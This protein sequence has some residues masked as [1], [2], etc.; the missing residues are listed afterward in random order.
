MAIK[1]HTYDQF[2]KMRDAGRL[3]A[4]VLDYITPYVTEGTSTDE[5]NNLCH[6]YILKH[7]AIPSPL[8]QGFPKS[9]C[10]SVNHVI[11]H[12][13]PNDEKLVEGDILNIDVCLKLNGWH[14]DTSRMFAIGKIARKAQR[15]IEVTKKALE[16]GIKCVKPGAKFGD[17]GRAIQAYVSSCNFSIV[18]D[19][20]GHGIGELLHDEPQVLHY[21]TFNPGAE[22]KEG[23]FFTIEPMIN[24]GGEAAIISNHDGWTVTT[25]DKSLS[26]QWEHTLGVTKDGV[27]IFTL[28]SSS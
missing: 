4:S 21:D 5:L 12:G 1:I 14:G 28:S 26:A 15:L 2:Q 18:K 13:I 6:N 7:N 3:A 11:C 10:T 24:A 20:C 17:I 27:E 22:I 16:L 25:R 19:Y 9:I 23:M 8:E